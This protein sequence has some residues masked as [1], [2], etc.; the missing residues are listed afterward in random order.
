M[1]EC[2]NFKGFRSSVYLHLNSI[3]NAAIDNV[4]NLVKNVPNI[5][6]YYIIIVQNLKFLT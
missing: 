4:F 3:L 1:L 6:V 2:T 5:I